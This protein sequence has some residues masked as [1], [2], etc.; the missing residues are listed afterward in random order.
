MEQE[1]CCRP[2]VLDFGHARDG[3]T[4]RL[5]T[6][7]T[8]TARRDE[9]E[10]TQRCRW[11]RHHDA[12]PR[13]LVSFPPFPLSVLVWRKLTLKRDCSLF[14]NLHHLRASTGLQQLPFD[15]T[16]PIFIGTAEY[17]LQRCWEAIHSLYEVGCL[18]FPRESTSYSAEV[19]D[20]SFRSFPN[21]LDTR[22]PALR[23]IARGSTR[24]LPSSLV[25]PVV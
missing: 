22:T 8:R 4:P 7:Q 11:P 17:S 3:Q 23:C 12:S 6:K 18:P 14:V 2:F 10:S 9:S 13:E 21:S 19:A 1:C 16:A 15:P 24:S 25:S 5:R 20:L